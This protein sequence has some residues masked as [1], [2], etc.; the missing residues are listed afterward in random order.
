MNP[1]YDDQRDWGEN[2]YFSTGAQH[3]LSTKRRSALSDGKIQFYDQ[4]H[5]DNL[6]HIIYSFFLTP[7]YSCRFTLKTTR[8]DSNIITAE[9]Y[10][11]PTDNEPSM[12]RQTN[13]SQ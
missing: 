13:Q 11:Y 10:V 5:T 2:G 12:N 7:N 6:I 4:N 8:N 1:S 9:L 3:F